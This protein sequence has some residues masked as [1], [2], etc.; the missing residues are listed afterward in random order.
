MLC[1]KTFLGVDATHTPDRDPVTD[2]RKYRYHQSPTCWN[3]E[4]YW[5]YLQEYGWGITYGNR[6]DSKTAVSTKPTLPWVTVHN[7]WKPGAHC[8]VWRQLN[9]LESILSKLL[10]SK[11]LPGSWSGLKNLLCSST[12]FHLQGTIQLLLLNLAGM[13]LVNL[14]CFRDFLK[15]FWVVTLV[16]KELSGGLECF[17]LRG[18]CYTPFYC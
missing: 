5:A 8:T 1:D 2:Q 12:F 4:F 14:L 15:L 9:R 17:N 11:P 13:G 7:S 18:N 10:W 16:F 3:N 6:N